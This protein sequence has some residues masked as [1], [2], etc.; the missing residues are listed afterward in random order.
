VRSLRNEEGWAEEGRRRGSGK[1]KGGGAVGGGR[2]DA[3]SH[4]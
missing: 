2:L 3:F 1:L 4:V